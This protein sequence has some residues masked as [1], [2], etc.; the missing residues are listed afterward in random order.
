MSKN[1]SINFIRFGSALLLLVVLSNFVFAQKSK[2]VKILDSNL[3]E[4]YDGTL[5]KLANLD[6][7][8]INHPNPSLRE[9]GFDA[10]NY[11]RT[12]LLN[13]GYEFIYPITSS[14]DTNYKLVYIIKGVSIRDQRLHKNLS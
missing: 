9:V 6:V 4:L 1:V 5:V 8:N 14:P 3:F 10:Y 2:I 13:R 7:P 12:V 11:A